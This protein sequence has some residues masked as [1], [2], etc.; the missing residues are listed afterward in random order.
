LSEYDK[1]YEAAMLLPEGKE[2]TAL[3][4]KMTELALAYAPWMLGR[5]PYANLIAQPWLKGYK[6]NPFVKHE[7]KF[8]DVVRSPG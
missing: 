3:Y 6:Q 4:R 5:N 2:R 7:W 8:Y 1:A